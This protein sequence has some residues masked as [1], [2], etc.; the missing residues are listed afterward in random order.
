MGV[1]SLFQSAASIVEKIKSTTFTRQIASSGDGRLANIRPSD[2]ATNSYFVDAISEGAVN[3]ISGR[4][5]IVRAPNNYN[6]D[7]GG[8]LINSAKHGARTAV[9]ESFFE[10]GGV[11]CLEIHDATYIP[12]GGSSEQRIASNVVNLTTG[13]IQRSYNCSTVQFG[14]A[15]GLNYYITF[16]PNSEV[17]DAGGKV[18]LLD[19]STLVFDTYNAT[20]LV[21]CKNSIGNLE[22]LLKFVSSPAANTL[23]LGAGNPV[24]T[25]GHMTFANGLTSGS[26]TT[27]QNRNRYDGA[28][29]V[30]WTTIA[31]NTTASANIPAYRGNTASGAVT[32][33]AFTSDG[34]AGGLDGHTIVLTRSGANSFIFAAGSGQTVNG[35][36]SFTLSADRQTVTARYVLADTDWRVA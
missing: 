9:I 12:A 16:A 34:F 28:Q 13:V 27:F 25:E 1:R 29:R 18:T 32:L 30:S 6:V 11:G 35:G 22:T 15:L 5:N 20:A 7:G 31:T 2:Y 8:S 23:V 36:A 17:A 33:T 4:L 24:Y 26:V 10:I 19:G 3:P 21:T 14:G